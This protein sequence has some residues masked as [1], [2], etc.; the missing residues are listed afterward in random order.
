MR[1]NL[2]S[3]KRQN[4]PSKN[5]KPSRPQYRR[6]SQYQQHALGLLFMIILFCAPSSYLRPIFSSRKADHESVAEILAHISRVG[7]RILEVL[8]LPSF[9]GGGFRLWGLGDLG[10]GVPVVRGL[11]LRV[12]GIWVEGSRQFGLSRVL[13]FLWERQAGVGGIP[14]GCGG[15]AGSSVFVFLS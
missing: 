14:R 12:F 8:G 5:L 2:K 13:G 9:L 10:F 11:R 3:S 6:R 15:L 1:P 7:L 4:P